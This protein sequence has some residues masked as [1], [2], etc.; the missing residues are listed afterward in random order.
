MNGV[1]EA[2]VPRYARPL[3]R[4]EVSRSLTRSSAR[5]TE[6]TRSKFTDVV[7]PLGLQRLAAL[8]AARRDRTP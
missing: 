7:G 1:A 2:T 8:D 5:F 6:S 3:R 4:F